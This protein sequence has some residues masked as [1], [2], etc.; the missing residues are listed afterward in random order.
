MSYLVKVSLFSWGLLATLDSLTMRFR[1]EALGYMILAQS[2]AGLETEVSHADSQSALHDQA[3]KIIMETKAQVNFLGWQY[4]VPIVT[5][6][7]Q[8]SWCSWL[9]WERTAEALHLEF[10]W[11]LPHVSL[12]LADFHMCPFTV[13]NDNC[14]YNSCQWYCESFQ[15]TIKADGGLGDP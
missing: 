12:P 9:H 10:L 2:L 14:Q 11:S 8:K 3:S 15:R 7:F 1:M 13:T 5:H 4:C 6:C